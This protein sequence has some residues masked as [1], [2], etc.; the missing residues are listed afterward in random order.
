MKHIK[1]YQL[2]E[3][4]DIDIRLDIRD[5]ILEL[6]DLGIQYS[7]KYTDYY[8]GKSSYPC[9]RVS[10]FKYLSWGRWGEQDNGSFLL[11][12]ITEVLLRIKDYLKET[13]CHIDIKLKGIG[14][15]PIDVF[16]EKFRGQKLSHIY[17]FIYGG[18]I[19]Y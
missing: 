19:Q 9:I 13:G 11:E 7:I 12:D 17:L 2:F 16:I 10:I 8:Q 6:E 14:D 18:N 1:S 15:Y 4:N 5:I 3:S